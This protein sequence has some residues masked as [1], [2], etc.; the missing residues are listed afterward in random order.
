MQTQ[1]AT[2]AE[3]AFALGYLSHLAAD[4]IAHNHYVPYHLA[5]YAR[6]KGPRALYWEMRADRF[7]AT[8]AGGS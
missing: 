6:S 5:R 4:T 3:R 8:R 1:A 2:D 7:V